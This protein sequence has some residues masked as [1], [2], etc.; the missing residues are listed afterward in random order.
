M[1]ALIEL[2]E[3]LITIGAVS[4]IIMPYVKTKGRELRPVIIIATLSIVFHELAHKFV[5]MGFGFIAVYHAN[6]WGLTIGVMLRLLGLPLFFIPAYVS[7]T[8][9]TNVLGFTLTALAGPLTNLSI[10]LISFIMLRYYSDRDFVYNNA[11][12]IYALMNINKWL[13][14]FNLLPIPGTDGFHVIN[15]LRLI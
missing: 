4:F 9:G 8:G 14:I 13:T 12:S 3:I 1:F 11:Q 15:S 7:I 2:I 6:I 5:A 10:Y